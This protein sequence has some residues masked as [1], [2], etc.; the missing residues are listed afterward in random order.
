[1]AD[2]SRQ[3]SK[4][5]LSLAISQRCLAQASRY[6]MIAAEIERSGASTLN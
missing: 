5:T 2:E 1:L 3:A 6:E 4:L